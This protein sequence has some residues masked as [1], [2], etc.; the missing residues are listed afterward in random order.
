MCASWY[1]EEVPRD[2]QIRMPSLASIVRQYKV[3]TDLLVDWLQ[4]ETNHRDLAHSVERLPPSC[5]RESIVLQARFLIKE[6]VV[7]PWW[8]WSD[9]QDGLTDRLFVTK[10]YR[11]SGNNTDGG[12]HASFNEA[13]ATVL[14]EYRQANLI[15]P[16][17]FET[18]IEYKLRYQEVVERRTN[19]PGTTQPILGRYEKYD[20]FTHDQLFLESRRRDKSTARDEKV[21]QGVSVASNASAEEQPQPNGADMHST[22]PSQ[23]HMPSTSPSQP[24]RLSGD[25]VQMYR[26]MLETMRLR[27]N[28]RVLAEAARLFP[29]KHSASSS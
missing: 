18:S 3:H 19:A 27:T 1:S 2:G 20:P 11:Q 5:I 14:H 13:M 6:N 12:S 26:A 10:I 23:P 28:A 8:L 9:A 17:T 4:R 15:Q 16:K 21:Y 29:N 25:T 24:T 7:M 22:S